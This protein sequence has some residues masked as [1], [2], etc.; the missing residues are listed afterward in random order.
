MTINHQQSTNNLLSRHWLIIGVVALAVA[1]L[2]SLTLV[3]GR[4]PGISDHAELQRIFHSA[5]VVHVDLSVLVWFLAVACLLFSIAAREAKTALPLEGGALWCFGLGIALMML[6]PFD[7]KSEALMSNYIPVISSPL[8]Y[9]SLSLILCGF[10]L[11]LIKLLSVRLSD[12]TPPLR[13]GLVSA[14]LI[15][16][17]AIAAFIWSYFL[18]PPI[19]EGEQYFEMLFWGGGHV[20]QFTHTQILLV[21]W[22]LLAGAIAPKHHFSPKLLY[23]LFALGLLA[24]A[25]TPFAYLRFDIT[26]SAFRNFFTHTMIGL[27]GLA[28]GIMG[29][30]LLPF[31]YKQRQI[32]ALWTALCASILLFLYGGF[33][34]MLIRGQNVVIPAHYHGSIVGITLAFM[35]LAYL[36]LPRLG[37]A[38]V[39]RWRTAVWQPVVSAIGQ[40]MHVSGL[41]YSGG[42]GVLRKTPGGMQDMALDVKVAMGFMGLGGVLAI[43]GGLMFVV[44]MVRAMRRPYVTF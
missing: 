43:A 13:F 12:F 4:A 14:G 1:G 26:S 31:L 8:F 27:G 18:L 23:S 6:S 37:Y 19:F 11:M 17:I 20:L 24:A 33:L 36:M 40:L 9:L 28:T 39:S 22:V 2:Y 34:A 15:S 5:L 10:S 32:N 16:V 7:G 44:V 41:A 3:L 35:G 42:Y 21:V 25:I 30:L 38:D 29:I